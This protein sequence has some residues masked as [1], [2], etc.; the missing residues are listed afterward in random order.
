[1][2]IEIVMPRLGWTMEEGTLVE[3][4]KQDGD[5][6]ETGD[7]VFT[8]ESDKALNEIESLDN[9]IL[10]IPDAVPQPGDT[11]PVGTFLAYLLQPGEEP[12]P[13]PAQPEAPAAKP[14]TPAAP[15][16]PEST[17]KKHGPTISPRALRIAT[18]LGVNWQ[19]LKGSGSTGRIVER[20][21]RAAAGTSTTTRTRRTI[22][23]RLLDS[24]QQTAAVTLHVEADATELVALRAR[25][26]TSLK[27]RA[28]TYNDMFLRLTALA[29]KDHPA[30]NASWQNEQA[31]QHPHIH[32]GIAVDTNAG[33]L[34]PVLQNADQKGLQQIATESTELAQKARAGTLTTEQLQ[35][36]TFTLT[37]LGMFGIDT[38]TPLLNLPQCAILGIGRIVQKPAVHEGQI[39]PRHMVALSLTFDHRVVDGSP[40]ARFLS[41]IRE[42]VE[43]PDLWL[44]R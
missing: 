5:P 9:G 20:D 2:P 16:T 18:E 28:P 6:V 34:V 42:F 25:L 21:I 3:W 1:M 26:K 27:D 7:I 31:V 38:F 41:T 32:L 37:N 36:G 39:V 19:T 23:Q 13:A 30:L 43:Q 40:A 24:A 11:V 10:H 8:V 33:L 29:L 22:A 12:L 15:K 14:A 44:T 17:T 4:I 35:N